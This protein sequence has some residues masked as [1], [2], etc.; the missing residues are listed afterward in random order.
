MPASCKATGAVL[1]ADASGASG[2]VCVSMKK[3]RRPRK[4]P[5]RI[6]KR[7]Q[8]SIEE[9]APCKPQVELGVPEAEADASGASGNVEGDGTEPKKLSKELERAGKRLER[10]E[11]ANSPGRTLDKPGSRVAVPNAR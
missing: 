7:L 5:E 2:H 8:R 4:A 3:P 10:M 6:S 11:E 9:Y 1:E